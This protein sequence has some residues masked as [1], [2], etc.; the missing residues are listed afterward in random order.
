MNKTICYPVKEIRISDVED[1]D[2]I[3]AQPMYEWQQ[4]EAGKYV[5]E[6]SNPKPSW[7]HSVDYTYYG[8][9]Y[10][11]RAYFTPQQLTYYK[12]RFE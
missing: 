10:V 2:L 8:N 1:P 4:T 7:H 6:N 12:L 5:M 9:V 11:I 3:V